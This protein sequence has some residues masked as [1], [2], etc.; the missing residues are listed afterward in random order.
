M[1][2][3]AAVP[4]LLIALAFVGIPLVRHRYGREAGMVAERELE[5]QGVPDRVLKE[6]NINFDA[7]GH[8]TAQGLRAQGA[9]RCCGASTCRR[10]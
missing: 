9:T 8:E 4:Q 5:R 2:T 1:M 7:G 6:H 3:F 10:C